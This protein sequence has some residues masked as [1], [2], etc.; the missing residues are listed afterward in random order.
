MTKPASIRTTHAAAP[1]AGVVR[2]GA[3]AREL[4]AFLAQ[5]IEVQCQ[6][7]GA[8]AGI[9]WLA[10]GE[11]RAGGATARWARDQI[12]LLDRDEVLAGLEQI[13]EQTRSSG[14]GQ[15]TSLAIAG[16]SDLYGSERSLRVLSSPLC[17]GDQIEGAT[18][19]VLASASTTRD[20]AALQK[21]GL[22]NANFESFL[23]RQHA[24]NEGRQK[25]LLREALELLDAAQQGQSAPAM[26]ATSHPYNAHT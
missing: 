26:H 10:S 5:L 11:R 8:I 2:A 24:M 16:S 20:E 25:M 22:T 6:L 21:V 1:G 14:R 18:A 7:A 17:A 9:A 13:C 4:A 23:W 15:I 3:S 19:L 12:D